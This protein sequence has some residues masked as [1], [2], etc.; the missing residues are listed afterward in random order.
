MKFK[1]MIISIVSTFIVCGVLCSTFVDYEVNDRFFLLFPFAVSIVTASLLAFILAVLKK[2]VFRFTL[3]DWLIT[4]G[5]IYYVLRYDYQLRIAD[6]KVIYAVLLL[7]LWYVM[8]V[9]FSS[10][11]ISKNMLSVGIIVI[12]SL[13]AFWGIL[14]LYGFCNSNHFFYRITGPFINPGPYSGYLAMLLPICFHN[15][16]LSK[17]WQ[18][19]YWWGAFALM[20]CIIAVPLKSKIAL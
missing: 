13:I 11:Q 19:Y 20:F 7:L 6:W 4:A 10:L 17:D 2:N 1:L 14:Q 16:L 8:R 3:A 15:L 9:I 5:V 12:G 18:R